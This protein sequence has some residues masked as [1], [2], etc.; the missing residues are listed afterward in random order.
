MLDCSTVVRILENAGFSASAI[1]FYEN[2]GQKWTLY[3]YL[4]EKIQ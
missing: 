3:G 2:I 4:L 1:I